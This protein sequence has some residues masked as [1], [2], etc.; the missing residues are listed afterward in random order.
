M[1]TEN[2]MEL[3]EAVYL[4]NTIYQYINIDIFYDLSEKILQD[5]GINNNIYK[6]TMRI[7]L[8][9]NYISFNGKKY[10]LKDEHKL[11]HQELLN[12]IN[13]SGQIEHF[14]DFLQKARQKNHFFF[15]NISDLE[16]EIYSRM[17][18]Q[19]THSIAENLIDEVNFS[20]TKVLELG[21]NSGGLASKILST[22]KDCNYTIIDTTIPCE[23]GKEFNQTNNL[24][25]QFIKGDFFNSQSFKASYDY[26]ILMNVL[27]DFN[28]EK[29]L[30][31][32]RNCLEKANDKAKFIIIEDILTDEYEPH[33]ILMH[34]LRL[35]VEC[36][37][38]KQRTT[39]ELL[40]L[41]ATLN[42]TMA[43]SKKLNDYY[44]MFIMA[45]K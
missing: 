43:K 24:N 20:N 39:A 4:F 25:I 40:E 38:G 13:N 21:G 37:G 42:Y 11:K 44:T 35:A 8:S 23:I 19:V 33:E 27:H 7:L 41:F 45:K 12:K 36:R 29:C 16:Y 2:Y 15:T 26:F 1:S 3:K 22:Y 14:D 10:I 5:I 9:T 32:I 34:G 6:A 18:F 28:D 31:I 30:Q 17:N